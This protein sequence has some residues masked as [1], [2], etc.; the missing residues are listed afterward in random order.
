MVF[1]LRNRILQPSAAQTSEDSP[2][3]WSP[4]SSQFTL[5]QDWVHG[6]Q[7]LHFHKQ[8]HDILTTTEVTILFTEVDFLQAIDP[9]FD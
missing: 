1:L 9:G 8:N 6:L 3:T 7:E 2:D 4:F 5:T